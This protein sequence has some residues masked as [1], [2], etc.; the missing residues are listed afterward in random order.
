LG[1]FVWR[2]LD[3]DGIQDPGEPGISAV[4]VRL[5]TCAG[6]YLAQTQT[7]ASG[8]YLFSNLNPGSYQVEFVLPG[9]YVFSPRYQGAN[10]AVDSNANTT[11]GRSDCVTLVA[12]ETNLTIDAGMYQPA[13]LGDF[14]WRD[15]DADGIQDPGEPGISTVTVRLYTC[16]GTYLAQTQTNATGYYLF[17]NLN[18]GSY[19]VEFVLPGG[20]VFSPRYQGANT[21]LDS[22]ANTTTGRSDCVTLVAGE[23]NLTIDAGMYQPSSYQICGHKYWDCT[24]NGLGAG[25]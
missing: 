25:R 12:G 11:T 2:D 14:V 8:Y 1:D 19:Q 10:T 5:Y 20:Y 6:T 18:P 15:L 3:A 4:T 16:A 9:G 22:N 7:N 13:A 17:S 21:A 24:T 23:T